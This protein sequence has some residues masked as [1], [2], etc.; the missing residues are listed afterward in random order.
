ML[1]WGKTKTERYLVIGLHRLEAMK[2]LGKTTIP[3]FILEGDERDA[4]MCEISENLHRADLE[5]V[6]YDEQV[7][8][9]G[10]FLFQEAQLISGCTRLHPIGRGRPKGGISEAARKLPVKRKTHAA[11]RKNVA[12]AVKIASIALK[13]RKQA[14][15]ALA[16]ITAPLSSKSRRKR[17]PMI[18]PRKKYSNSRSRRRQKR[19]V[20]FPAAHKEIL[21]DLSMKALEQRQGGE[22]S[23]H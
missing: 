15:K 8:E 3:C 12:R 18:T 11:K 2:Q 14:K 19:R 17:R 9:W 6:E 10:A 4:R 7:A 20:R 21:E 1:G 22:T 16:H 13:R 5:P 23:V